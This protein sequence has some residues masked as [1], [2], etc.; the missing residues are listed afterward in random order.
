MGNFLAGQLLRTFAGFGQY[1]VPL[2]LLGGAIASYIGKRK[3]E[4]LV[5]KAAADHTGDAIRRMTWREFEMFV[6]QLYRMNGFTVVETGGGGADGGVDLELR[7][8]Q[9]LFLVQCKQ[10]R[11]YKVSVNVVRELYGVMVD[12]GAAGG[13]VVTSGIYT[14]DAKAFAEGKNISLVDGATLAANL[15]RVAAASEPVARERAAP[16]PAQL[17]ALQCPRCGAGMV[18]RI[19]RQGKNAGNAF[20]GCETF[21]R[22]RGVRGI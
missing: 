3:R 11:A 16:A 15:K 5:S 2:A 17:I 20:W 7:R 19:A 4:G 18:Q 12:R 8:G 22:C 9:E 13:F 1:V 10:W 21:P 6:G 14:T